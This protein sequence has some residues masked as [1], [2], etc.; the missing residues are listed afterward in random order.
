MVDPG[1]EFM[2]ELTKVLNEKEIKIQRGSR[3]S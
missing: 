1:K 2:G 3:K